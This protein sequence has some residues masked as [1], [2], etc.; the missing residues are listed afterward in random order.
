S[1][2]VRALTSRLEETA[3]V[4]WGRC[5][6][7][8]EGI[9]YWP[10]IEMVKGAAGIQHDD[11]IEETSRKLGLLLEALGSEDLDELRTMAVALANLVAA[12]TTPRG[13]YKATAITKGELHWGVRRVFHLLAR[14]Q[15]VILVFENL[16]W[17][18]PS[19]RALVN[20]M[21]ELQDEAPILV[22][23]AERAEDD[24]KTSHRNHRV[25]ELHPLT[26]DESRSMLKALFGG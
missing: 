7:Y 18:D 14:T 12:P 15:P 2:I 17:A 4:L 5:L 10:V 9:T 11:P 8:G 21:L 6:D 23:G 1:R 16:H 19:L 20:S 13:T 22:I 24:V 25:I 26:E 3:T